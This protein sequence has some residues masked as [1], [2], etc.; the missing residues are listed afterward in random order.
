MEK[1]CKVVML[2]TKETNYNN[3]LVLNKDNKLCAWDTTS[4]GSQITLPPQNIYITSDDEIKE[5]DWVLWGE[6]Q[7]QISQATSMDVNLNS[8]YTKGAFKKI[9]A[10]TDKSL[11]PLFCKTQTK[12]IPQISQSFINQYIESYNKGNVITEVMVEYE[13]IKE[14]GIKEYKGNILVFDNT[15]IN[16][17]YNK[18]KINLDN[19]IN[20]KPIKHGNCNNMC[21]HAV[22]L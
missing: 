6:K 2:A 9:I 5:G 17:N 14:F 1:K 7:D 11:I 4:M 13:G 19:T 12:N 18:L 10:T 15:T 3:Y 21:M 20:I 22:I 16:L 8:S